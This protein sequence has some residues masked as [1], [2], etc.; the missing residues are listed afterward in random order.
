[1]SAVEPPAP[2]RVPHA[3]EQ[4]EGYD[5][6][7]RRDDVGEERPEVVRR[8]PLR[9]RERQAGDERGLALQWLKQFEDPQSALYDPNIIAFAFKCLPGEPDWRE[10]H[11]RAGALEARYGLPFR[12]YAARLRPSA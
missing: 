2:L 1:M 5:R 8:E 11:R 10:L 3:E 4:R 9:D 6:R 12:K 7:E